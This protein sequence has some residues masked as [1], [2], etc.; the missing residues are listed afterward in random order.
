MAFVP[1]SESQALL[2]PALTDEEVLRIRNDFP[3]LSRPM[4]G[5]PLIYL[6]SGATSQ[7]PLS[8]IEAEQEFYEQRNAAVHRGAHLLAVEA[9]DSFEDAR[10]TLAA[11]L[12]AGADEIIWTSNATEGLNLL[13]YAFLNSSLPGAAAPAA[14]FALG[15]GDEIVVTEME[16]HANLIPWQQ[17]AERTGAT[18]RFIPVD[19]AGVLDLEAAD[20]IISPATRVL[21][22][23]HAS[24][25]LG[26]I[27]P[28][29]KLVG[30]ARQVGALTVLDACQSAP[31]LPLDVRDL[32]VD[33]A[34]LSG[35]KMLG[36]TGI[37]VLYGRSELLNAL[38]PFLTGGS[39]I[40]T[41][42]MERA[43]FL[44]APQRFEAGTQK[45]SQAIAL[46]AAANYLTETGMDRV[47]AWESLL[48]QRLVDGLASI[49]GV[50]VLGP[51]PGQERIGLASFDV[52][53]VHAHDVG[54]YLD[55]KGIAVRVG[56]HCAQPLHRRLGLTASTRASTYLYN[57]TSDVD[58]F[59]AAVAEVRA[60]FGA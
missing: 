57:T 45:V 10:E 18:L 53:G 40:T 55:S 60:Y 17:L 21:A 50:R 8:V 4:G 49:P 54:Q 5:H 16:H 15:A 28:V 20:G 35:H 19:D 6:D 44:P 47:H 58:A 27:N 2:T 30:M 9:T 48:G 41:V 56:H 59:L 37:G 43:A 7:N 24:N 52:A 33:F 25:V 11:F 38:P 39:M 32:G 51:G 1:T 12:G 31:H 3:I 46:A 23:S 34:V 26:T 36:P 13:S 42:T 14:R 22:F 29:K